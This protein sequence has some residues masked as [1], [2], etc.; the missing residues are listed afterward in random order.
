MS[1]RTISA[2][3]GLGPYILLT[4]FSFFEVK[5]IELCTSLL[6]ASGT[7]S[8]TTRRHLELPW[9]EG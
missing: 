8:Q 5:K 3:K 4:Y 9:M 6:G 1:P 7:V 2:A